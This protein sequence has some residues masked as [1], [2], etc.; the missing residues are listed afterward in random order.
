MKNKTL[1]VF[2]EES[3][4]QRFCGCFLFLVG[5]SL[6]A[7]YRIS[8]IRRHGVTPTIRRIP[9]T[10]L[11]GG[12]IVIALAR[13]FARRKWR[14]ARVSAPRL[15]RDDVLPYKNRRKKKRDCPVRIRDCWRQPKNQKSALTNRDSLLRPLTSVL[16]W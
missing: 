4:N 14:R 11:D 12:T 15:I 6:T 5:Q 3:K 13:C 10:Q 8:F 1:K 2:H 7:P 16:Y 9:R